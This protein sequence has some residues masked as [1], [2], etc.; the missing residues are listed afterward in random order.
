M[1]NTALP[2]PPRTPTYLSFPGSGA[3]YKAALCCQWP[4]GASSPALTQTLIVC[5]AVGA[6]GATSA[7]SIS[8]LGKLRPRAA[9]R[10]GGWL[11]FP[12]PGR[13]DMCLPRIAL[14]V[15][16]LRSVCEGQQVTICVFQ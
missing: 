4:V 13:A 3:H 12:G 6:L 15:G 2:P 5:R 9:T 16:A 11:R 7:N 10:L 1:A 8:Q 14:P